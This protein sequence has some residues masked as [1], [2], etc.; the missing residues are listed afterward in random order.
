MKI[1]KIIALGGMVFLLGI[2]SLWGSETRIVSMGYYANFYVRD[3]YNIWGFP[4]TLVGYR[5]KVFIDSYYLDDSFSN[6]FGLWR[7]G[8][9]IPVTET[10]TLGVY[11]DNTT[12][13][14]YHADTKFT[15]SLGMGFGRDM[16]Y[17]LNAD[18]AAHQFTLFGG[19]RLTNM[20]VAIFGISYSSKFSFADPDDS[21]NNFEDKLGWRAFGVGIGTKIN[22]RTRFEGTILYHSGNFDHIENKAYRDT[23]RWRQPEDY[24]GYGAMARLFYAY[25]PR[26]IFVPFASYMQANEGYRMLVENVSKTQNIKIYVDKYSEYILGLGVDLI[27]IDN[28]LVTLAGGMEIY[29]STYTETWYSGTPPVAGKYTYR[30]LPFISVGLESRITK[31]LTARFSFYELLETWEG[32]EPSS[33]DEKVLTKGRLTGSTYAA[34]FGLAFRLG[35]FTIDTLVDTDYFADFLHNGPYLLSGKEHTMGLFSQL[36]VTYN[37]GENK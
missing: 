26:V 32:Q 14:L 5:S 22:E 8:I 4:S 31:W 1:L 35:R 18:E 33:G 11:L 12:Y 23:L 37:F 24:N 36:T 15:D 21:D 29:S 6:G 9:H 28:N 27:P 20:D 34:R 30:S 16:Y 17:N 25:S 3:S 7:G 2:T 19:L 13:R 10:F